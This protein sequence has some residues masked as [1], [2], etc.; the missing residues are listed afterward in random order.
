MQKNGTAS[1]IESRFD[2]LKERARNLVDDAGEKAGQ[3]KERAMEA[4][5]TIVESGSQALDRVRS[6]IKEHPFVALGVA[7][8]VGYVAIRMM[9]K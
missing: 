4:K 1:E 3:L 2:S 8:S 6:L 5:H 7:F 9:R